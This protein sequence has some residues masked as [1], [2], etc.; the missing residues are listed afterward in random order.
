MRETTLPRADSGVLIRRRVCKR[1]VVGEGMVGSL[2]TARTSVKAL[3]HRFPAFAAADAMP[4]TVA[5]LI[6]PKNP[7]FC[8]YARVESHNTIPDSIG[9]DDEA[10]SP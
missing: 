1:R 2:K 6:A 4:N 7:F 8:R 9:P 3:R 5:C 10:P